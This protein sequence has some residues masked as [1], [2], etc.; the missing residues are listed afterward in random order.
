MKKLFRK[1][2][3][4]TLGFDHESLGTPRP[5]RKRMYPDGLKLY[6]RVYPKLTSMKNY[7]VLELIE[8][9]ERLD[10]IIYNKTMSFDDFCAI[11][12][13]LN[14]IHNE[15]IDVDDK[16]VKETLALF[17]YKIND[18]VLIKEQ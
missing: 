5:G 11:T 3:Y 17:G 15:D 9:N 18:G 2:K 13:M 14:A 10:D 1:L 4:R 16:I 7:K 8:D 12:L 6:L